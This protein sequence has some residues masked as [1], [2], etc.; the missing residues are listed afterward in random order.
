M[1]NKGEL[2]MD[3]KEMPRL[4]VAQIEDLLATPSNQMLIYNHANDTVNKATY[5]GLPIGAE[6]FYGIADVAKTR[7]ERYNGLNG[8][9]L[10]ASAIKGTP[11]FCWAGP[12]TFVNYALADE[13]SKYILANVVVYN[14][15]TQ[16][17]ET[18]P[19][20]WYALDI[21]QL[22]SD[23]VHMGLYKFWLRMVSFEEERMRFLEPFSKLR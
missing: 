23:G 14:P 5:A 11:E 2:D 16:K 3:K 10:V 12:N 13:N 4:R 22:I 6:H 20:G 17:F 9:K 21:K 15:Q 8:R 19:A 1:K 7:L 18:N